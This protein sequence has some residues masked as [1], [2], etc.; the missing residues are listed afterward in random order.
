MKVS[1]EDCFFK[2]GDPNYQIG[3][4]RQPGYYFNAI[5]P[6][7]ATRMHGDEPNRA[8]YLSP[9]QKVLH[10]RITA[11][12]RS[13]DEQGGKSLFARMKEELNPSQY[14]NLYEASLNEYHQNLV[15]FLDKMESE[16]DQ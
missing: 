7:Q 2:D 12:Y 10:A 16:R 15:A 13:L 11:L 6:L 9:R 5:T 8:S 1:A 14:R 3:L 4:Y